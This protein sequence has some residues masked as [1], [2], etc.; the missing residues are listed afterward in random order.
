MREI[1]RISGGV[2]RRAQV[3]FRYW[4]Q[5]EG[6]VEEGADMVLRGDMGFVLGLEEWVVGWLRPSILDGDKMMF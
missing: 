1:R 4:R 5:R 2:L 6:K 3:S